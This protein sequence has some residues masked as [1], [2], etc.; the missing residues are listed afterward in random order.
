MT[1]SIASHPW[2]HQQHHRPRGFKN[3]WHPPESQPFFKSAFW[4]IQ[5][6]I[7][8]RA[9]VLPPVHPGIPAPTTTD[10]VR[11]TWIGHS[12]MLIQTPRWNLLTDPVFSDRVSPFS[13]AGPKREVALPFGVDD[14]PPIDYVLISHDHYDHLD[15]STVQ[16]LEK[17]HAPHFFVPLGVARIL[18]G[19]GITQV[20]E[21][22]WWQYADLDGW[23]FHCTPAQHFSGRG[24]TRNGT[25][26]ASW[27]LESLEDT[28]TVYYGADSGY[29][30]LFTEI[31]ERLGAP[32]IAL[33]PI[34]AYLPRWFMQVVHMEPAE[35]VQAF[36]D[37]GATHFVPIHWGTFDLADELL[38][39]PP[40][41]LREAAAQ[42]G[43]TDQ[44]QLLDL[45]HSFVIS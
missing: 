27:Y 7:G 12:S 42:H 13:F 2:Y 20:V 29:A 5:H 1:I 33:L 28:H 40:Q 44:I 45:G 36:L 10:A 17:R 22:D 8:P 39:E 3:I 26:W 14:L 9:H 43:L 21:M 25:L 23:R 30:P 18:R 16:A 38:H 11:L 34:G 37:L 19:W 6:G 31:R 32:A 41:R 15:K 4:V 35:S 24:L